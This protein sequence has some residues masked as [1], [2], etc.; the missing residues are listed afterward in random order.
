MVNSL[1]ST[2]FALKPQVSKVSD[3]REIDTSI[4][5]W[6]EGLLA[7]NIFIAE[8]RG[9][10]VTCTKNNSWRQCEYNPDS[11]FKYSFERLAPCAQDLNY[12]FRLWD[13]VPKGYELRTDSFEHPQ[14]GQKLF[15]VYLRTKGLINDD[16]IIDRTLAL[17]V[18]KAWLA[19]TDKEVNNHA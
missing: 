8:R 11:P 19:L 15:R 17:A 1:H 4:Q 18:S 13:S 10:K 6:Y 14:S 2:V 3:W 12:A 5:N 7:L 16:I 9:F